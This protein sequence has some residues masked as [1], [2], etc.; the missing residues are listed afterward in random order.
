VDGLGD[1]ARAS[2]MVMEWQAEEESGEAVAVLVA[3]PQ[4]RPAT[5]AVLDELAVIVQTRI[6]AVVRPAV[7]PEPPE[8]MIGEPSF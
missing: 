4:R 6:A 2:S 5:E 3:A 1:R 8:E 7:A